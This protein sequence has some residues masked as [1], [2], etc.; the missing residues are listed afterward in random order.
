M[1]IRQSLFYANYLRSIGWV[2][3]RIDKTNYFIKHFPIIGSIMK[4]QRPESLNFKTID[5]LS[6][7]HGV[8]KIII[9][10]LDKN[11][12][13]ILENQ[14]YKLSKNPYLP[15]K[16]LEINL[17]Q[18]KKTILF[19]MNKDTRR[20]AKRGES[21]DIREVKDLTKFR[22]YWKKSVK[23]SRFVP[24]I[25]HLTSFKAA[26]PPHSTI[27]LAS[28]NIDAE[29]ISG[30]IFSRVANGPAYYWQAFSSPIGRTTPSSTSLLYHGILWAKEHGSTV[31]DFEGIFDPRFP[32]KSWQGFSHFKRSFG[33]KEK[34]YPGTY[35]KF[36]F[37]VKKPRIFGA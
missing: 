5:N 3:K 18:T 27:F 25:S 22:C 15:T 36:Q 33:G 11:A 8:F 1:D 23:R 26:F 9:E 29:I 2:V 24:P 32:N 4:I 13:K 37:P 20:A 14:G 19:A 10:P 28:H 16:T 7:K 12:I 34:V 35:T 17:K 6:H 21:L 31:F 30:A